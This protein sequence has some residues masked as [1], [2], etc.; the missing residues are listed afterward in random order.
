MLVVPFVQWLCVCLLS[1]IYDYI[2]LMI[3]SL[4]NVIC[5]MYEN[6]SFWFG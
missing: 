3:T 1:L 2:T 5:N 6:V 4:C